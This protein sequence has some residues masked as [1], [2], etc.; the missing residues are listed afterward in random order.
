MIDMHIHAVYPNLP[1]V[2]PLTELYDGPVEKLVDALTAEMDLS[3]TTTLLGMGHLGGEEGDPLGVSSTL[4]VAERLPALKAIGIADPTRTSTD[5][6]QQV[7]TQLKSGAVVALKGY[8]GYVHQGPDSP[9]YL[10]YYELATRFGLP[11]IFHTGD[12]WSRRAKVRYA[13][14]LHLDE[15]AVDHPDLRI[16]MAHFGNP[17]CMDAAE[18]IYKNDNVW[19]DVSAILVGDSAHFEKI[20]ATGY[21]GR[22]VA[23]VRH[24]VEFTERPD[25]FLYGTDWPLAPM[26]VYPRFVEQLFDERDHQAVF[27]DNAKALFGL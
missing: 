11:F 22:T 12:N 17:W 10:P 21:L 16:V 4:R 5:H 26:N 7:E 19:A 1:G 14:P 3:G 18:V 9:G 25:R 23:R 2:K 24:A 8:L 27:E 6:L 20:T 13:H 15:V